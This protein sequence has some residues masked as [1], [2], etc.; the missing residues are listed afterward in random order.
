MPTANLAPLPPPSQTGP[1]TDDVLRVGT[2]MNQLLPK[3]ID[4]SVQSGIPPV[5]SLRIENQ[6]AFLRAVRTKVLRLGDQLSKDHDSASFA[7]LSNTVT[8]AIPP[9]TAA[10]NSDWANIDIHQ[11]PT[12]VGYPAY[13]ALAQRLGLSPPD[14]P[15]KAPARTQ[16]VITVLALQRGLNQAGATLVADGKWGPNTKTALETYLVSS[17]WAGTVYTV[18]GANITLPI[19]LAASLEQLSMS[20]GGGG[21]VAPSIPKP[22]SGA[23]TAATVQ[24]VPSTVATASASSG[25]QERLSSLAR[26]PVRMTGVALLVVGLGALAT[27]WRAGRWPGKGL[28]S[29]R[30]A[31]NGLGAGSGPTKILTRSSGIKA[32]EVGKTYKQ[33]WLFQGHPRT[34]YFTVEGFAKNGKARGTYVDAD[35]RTYRKSFQEHAHEWEKA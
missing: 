12:I 17:G 3:D 23:S 26:D 24:T 34:S 31:L 22:A 11:S 32:F 29:R 20:P 30:G 7:R 8:Q 9:A 19:E 1:T 6:R 5:Y 33:R 2:R 25:W 4:Q 28:R 14:L 35:G 18:S 10:Y 21:T 15:T 27:E 13:D 16:R